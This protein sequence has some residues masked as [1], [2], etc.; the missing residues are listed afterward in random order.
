MH[1]AG[2]VTQW[3]TE[4]AAAKRSRP[5]QLRPPGAE[6]TPHGGAEGGPKRPLWHA[7]AQVRRLESRCGRSARCDRPTG[8]SSRHAEQGRPCP[9]V[10]SP[11][12][13]TPTLSMEACLPAPPT[14]TSSTPGP[15]RR[16]PPPSRPRRTSS[17]RTRAPASSARSS[18]ARRTSSTSRT[19]SAR[20]AAI[21]SV[22]ASGSTAAPS[23]SSGRSS[24]PRP[25][26]CA[27]RRARPT[28]SAPR[29]GWPARAGSTS[30][31]S[32]TPS[33]SRR[34]G[35]TTCASRA[36]SSS[37]CTGST[38]CRPSCATSGP[39]RDG[40]SACSSTTW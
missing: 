37:R 40:G 4:I 8:A 12:R 36:S 38:T 22:P 33:W 10:S 5:Q 3:V 13:T 25:G 14:T 21:R 18:A 29:R 19:G 15:S 6:R 30:R 17:S 39:G 27:A 23:S 26:R 20:C 2:A 16:R 24:R 7:F 35:A 11:L 28:W 9:G 32:T 1:G 31:A 34:C